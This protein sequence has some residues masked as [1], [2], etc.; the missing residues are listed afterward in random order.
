MWTVHRCGLLLLADAS[1]QNKLAGRLLG[2][3]LREREEPLGAPAWPMDEKA[4]HCLE[5][6]WRVETAH[7]GTLITAISGLRTA[8]YCWLAGPDR[9][10]AVGKKAAVSTNHGRRNCPCA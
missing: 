7:R 8:G 1:R 5:L 10:L 4:A 9:A 3:R 6:G 2:L